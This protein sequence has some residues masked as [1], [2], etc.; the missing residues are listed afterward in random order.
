M[1]RLG[2]VDARIL[3][4]LQRLHENWRSV[5]ETARQWTRAVKNE[6]ARLGSEYGF[7][8]YAAGCDE[9]DSGEWVFDLSWCVED[10]TGF[11]DVALAMECEWNPNGTMDDF[12]KLVVARATHR[13]MICW[14]PTIA[15]WNKCLEDFLK[16]V[17]IYK[18]SAVGDRYL[19]FCWT[20]DPDRLHHAIHVVGDAV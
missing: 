20:N 13:V 16:Q 4:A 17:R 2:D 11:Q 3:A 9:S 19:F 12:Q 14:Q 1:T 7:K 6:I 18:G 15:A 10:K 5:G 8:V